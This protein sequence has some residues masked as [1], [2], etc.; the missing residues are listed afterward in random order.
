MEES[1]IF[2]VIIAGTRHFS[3]YPLLERKCDKILSKIR[4]PIQIVSGKAAG[5]DS[6]GE[7]YAKNR[8]YEIKEFPAPWLDIEGKP[9]SQIKIRYDGEKYWTKAG[10]HRNTQMADYA[11]ALIVFWNG[12]SRGT[13]DMIEKARKR[14]LKVRIIKY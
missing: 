5:A 4:Q 9:K 1:K 10:T 2:K 8:G 6:L 13:K 7:V 3:N 11:D 14:N 12:L